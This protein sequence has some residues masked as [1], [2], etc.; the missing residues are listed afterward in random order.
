M[1]ASRSAALITVI[2]LAALAGCTGSSTTAAAPTVVRPVRAV[3][4]QWCAWYTPVTEDGEQVIVASIGTTCG[5]SPLIGWVAE[6][7]GRTW[8]STRYVTG[9]CI[10][11]LKRGGVVVQI[12]QTGFAKAAEDTAGYLADAF[13]RAGWQVQV[14]PSG[15]GPTPSPLKTPIGP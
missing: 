6:R 7:T 1:R 10:A 12:W 8:L 3:P 5:G 4:P 9:T 2:L 13:E 15:P 14:A 11:Q